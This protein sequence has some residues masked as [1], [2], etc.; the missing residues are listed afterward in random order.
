MHA[1]L[2][3]VLEILFLEKGVFDGKLEKGENK[4]RAI[5]KSSERAILSTN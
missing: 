2:T 1:I 4:S 3:E 5:N